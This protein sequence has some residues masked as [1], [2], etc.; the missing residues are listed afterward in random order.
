MFLILNVL[1]ALEG[2]LE[3]LFLFSRSLFRDILIP[4]LSVVKVT[5][6][7]DLLLSRFL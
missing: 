2:T 1:S 7:I 4:E 3:D 6:Q 5:V